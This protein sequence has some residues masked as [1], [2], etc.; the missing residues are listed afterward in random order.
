MPFYSNFMD[1]AWLYHEHVR[2]NKI[3]PA[4]PSTTTKVNERKSEL[5]TNISI[6]V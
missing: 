1:I 4:L 3:L 2:K 6:Y 5:T